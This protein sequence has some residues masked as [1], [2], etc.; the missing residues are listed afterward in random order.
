MFSST[1]ICGNRL[2]RWKTMPMLR[3][4]AVSADSGSSCRTLPSCRYPIVSP[5]TTIRPP[6]G[7]SRWLM[8]RRNVLFPEPLGPRMHTTSPR[9]TSRLMSFRTTFLPNDLRTFCA[10]TIVMAQPFLAVFCTASLCPNRRS[11]R[12]WKNDRITVTVRYQRD[13]TI[14][15]GITL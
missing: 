5:S 3:R 13:A 2:K 11:I 1:V 8:Q 12:D 9:S 7:R 15:R 14:S 6:S 10:L 4:W